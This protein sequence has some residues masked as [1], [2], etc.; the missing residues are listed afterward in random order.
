MLDAFRL[1]ASLSSSSACA[2]AR[3]AH[4]SPPW[5]VSPTGAF[6][7]ATYPTALPV[8]LLPG[9]QFCTHAR[10]CLPCTMSA[11]LLPGRLRLC[12]GRLFYDCSGEV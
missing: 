3:L 5:S 7:R 8:A 4:H 1:A 11:S 10:A 6:A 2:Q 12:P 9:S